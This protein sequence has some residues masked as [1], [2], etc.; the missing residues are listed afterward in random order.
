M[1]AR[2]R[3]RR[4]LLVTAVAAPIA[5]ATL[6]VRAVDPLA[7]RES[8]S[9]AAASIA[10]PERREARGDDGSTAVAAEV[11][12]GRPLRPALFPATPAPAPP[13]PPVPPPR[14]A[15]PPAV[16]LLGTIVEGG[17]VAAVLRVGTG[18]AAAVEIRRA[19][20]SLS[21]LPDVRVTAVGDGTAT[22]IRGATETSLGKADTGA[23]PFVDA[24]PAD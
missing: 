12:W 10:G 4:L 14:A 22:L 11:P 15:P 3:T 7:G 21:G 9:R 16:E 8:G 5:A 2:S 24:G 6:S 1:A 20:E 19:G 13:S 17:A 23:P 18:P